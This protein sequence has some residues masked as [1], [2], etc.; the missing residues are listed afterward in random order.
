MWFLQEKKGE[1]R[2]KKHREGG[3]LVCEMGVLRNPFLHIEGEPKAVDTKGDDGEQ[4]PLNVV[5]EQLGTVAVEGESTTVNNSILGEPGVIHADSP[6]G[7]D[8]ECE[9]NNDVGCD[10]HAEVL[11]NVACKFG[12]HKNSPL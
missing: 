1:K 6:R 10:V 5:A 9:N 8:T 12:F 2:R 4:E 7:S 3:K 11:K